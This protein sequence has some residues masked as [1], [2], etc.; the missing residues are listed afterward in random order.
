MRK[1]FLFIAAL[2]VFSTGCASDVQRPKL[3]I[4]I[5]VDQ[6]RWDYL[7]YYYDKFGEG[8]FK[9]M[10]NEGF[11]YDNMNI[12]YTP[13]VTACG[14]SSVYTGSVPSITGIAGNNFYV[15]DKPVYCT[16]DDSVASIGSN[17]DTGK[18][19]PHYLKV[20]TLCDQ[21]RTATDF[22]SRVVSVSIKDR[23]A[24]L[25]GGHTA[26]AAYWYDVKNGKFITSSYYMKK[27]PTWVELFN[28]EKCINPKEDIRTSPKGN[29]LTVDMA[30]AVLRNEKLGQG[31]TTDIL[32]I[33]FSSTDYV[34]H[35]YGTRGRITEE[36]YRVLDRDL[37]RLFQEL[38]ATVGRGNYLAFLTADHGAA[39]NADFMTEHHIPAGR[40]N[41]SALSKDIN[42]I[43]KIKAIKDIMDYRIYLDHNALKAAK[44]NEEQVKTTIINYLQAQPG[45][46][47]A[48]DFKN[49]NAGF[50]PA[51]IKNRIIMGYYPKRSGDIQIIPSPGYYESQD[52][53]KDPGTTHGVWNP[54]DTHIPFLLYGWNVKHGSS[55][56]V[57]TI[58]DIAPTICDML[59]IQ[60][61]NGCIGRPLTSH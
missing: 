60:Q 33:S 36:T 37:A 44:M 52:G 19:S 61:P 13:T 51:A 2:F 21:L 1:I 12:Q 43:C 22:K 6:M 58:S 31:E 55:S 7:Y 3:V 4:G 54:Y 8:G 34:G 45:I 15:N 5:I 30:I 56:E 59:H 40:L 47:Y 9:R 32:A 42:D 28:K 14:H 41:Y 50:I 24:I 53:R 10:M 39:H 46:D 29:T 48:V 20:T 16:Q 35:K 38:D 17:G 23:G 57:T 49:I 25:P 18:M 11:S 27:L 26:N